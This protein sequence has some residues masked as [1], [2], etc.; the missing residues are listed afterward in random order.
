MTWIAVVVYLVVAFV[1]Y[2]IGYGFGRDTAATQE[3]TLAYGEGKTDG[4]AEGME[5]GKRIAQER[6]YHAGRADALDEVNRKAS[7]RARKAWVTR[8]GREVA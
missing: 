1:A 6:S 8:K 7:E 4:Y 2:R 5:M 3:Q